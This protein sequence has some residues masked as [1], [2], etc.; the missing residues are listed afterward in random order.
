MSIPIPPLRRVSIIDYTQF[1]DCHA[2]NGALNGYANQ[3][4]LVD[5]YKANLNG[6][7]GNNKARVEWVPRH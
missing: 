5:A 7:S 2:A 6:L 1:S 3:S 4:R